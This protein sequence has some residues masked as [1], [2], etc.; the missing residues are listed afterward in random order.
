MGSG[1][2]QVGEKC[3]KTDGRGPA[4]D[5]R[6]RVSRI[7]ELWSG[8]RVFGGGG[9]RMGKTCANPGESASSCNVLNPRAVACTA[10]IQMMVWRA[11]DQEGKKRKG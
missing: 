2:E 6:H 3:E 10:T 8:Q 7:R 9:R 4:Q 5:T 1:I 11:E